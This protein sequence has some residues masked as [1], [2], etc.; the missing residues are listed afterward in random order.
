MSF[1]YENALV[2]LVYASLILL[3]HTTYASEPQLCVPGRFGWCVL[4]FDLVVVVCQSASEGSQHAPQQADSHATLPHYRLCL[5]VP[6]RNL[7]KFLT[8][9]V[10][11]KITKRVE[12]SWIWLGSASVTCTKPEE[13]K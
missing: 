12:A 8:W 3:M 1:F 9:L 10:E 13:V 6:S 5:E 7:G 4:S 2:Q 11:C